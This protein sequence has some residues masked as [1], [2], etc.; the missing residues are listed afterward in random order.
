MRPERSRRAIRRA[1]VL[2]AIAAGGVVGA[3]ARYA[4]AVLMGGGPDDFP[5][6]TL[7]VN[8]SGCVLIGVLMVLVTEVTEPHRLVRP[9]LAVGFLG[10]FTTFSTF[11]L[12]VQ[13]LLLAGRPAA[14]T[15]YLVATVSATPGGTW[16]GITTIRAMTR[17]RAWT[18]SDVNSREGART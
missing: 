10:G 14:A 17:H 5:W 1:P 9:F 15:A 2:G 12:D 7:L 18:R 6:S 13:S 16:L 4:A 11:G 3:E 8:A